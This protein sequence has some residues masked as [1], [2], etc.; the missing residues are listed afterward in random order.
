MKQNTDILSLSEFNIKLFRED[1]PISG[2]GYISIN[3]C[4]KKK[5]DI[6]CEYTIHCMFKYNPEK[7]MIGFKKER[8]RK[9]YLGKIQIQHKHNMI[10]MQKKLSISIP[11]YEPSFKLKKIN[12]GEIETYI[13]MYR[14]VFWDVPNAS[15]YRRND[16]I[17]LLNRNNYDIC[18]FYHNK[19]LI[20]FCEYQISKK[21]ASI[22]AIGILQ[23]FRGNG[24][25]HSLLHNIY[26]IFAAENVALIEL[27]ASSMNIPAIA[28]YKKEGFRVRKTLSYWYEV[29]Y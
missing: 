18:F 13:E 4:P 2:I 16:I 29:I 9:K 1:I 25:A 3:K 19:T 21:N 14:K 28:L 5:L 20:G 15:F 23:Q 10:T 7:L 6:V 27:T 22:E 17:N 12:F 11:Q 24:Y 26:Y 8:Y